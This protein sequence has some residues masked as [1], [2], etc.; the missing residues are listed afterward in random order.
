MSTQERDLVAGLISRALKEVTG[1]DPGHSAAAV[2][3]PR[4]A[5]AIPPLGL[6]CGKLVALQGEAGTPFVLY[7]AQPGS[8]ALVARALVDLHPNDVGRDVMLMFEENDP[9]RPVIMGL[10]REGLRPGH[11][12]PLEVHTEG[13]RLIVSA[14]EQI[15]IRCGKASITLTKAGK[16]LIEGEYVISRARRTNRVEGGAVQIN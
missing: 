12:R 7:R 11:R 2:P 13:E 5:P 10:L 15:A 1:A 6:I 16:V 8:A 14:D 4:P 3:T 9:A